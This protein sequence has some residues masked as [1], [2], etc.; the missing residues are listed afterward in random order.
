ME[1]NVP[2]DAMTKIVEIL[3][4]LSS[5]DRARAVSAALTL[6]G[7]VQSKAPQEG[8]DD[9]I[10]SD[11]DLGVLS[12]RTRHWMNQNGISVTELQHVFHVVDGGAEVIS[13]IPGRNKKEQTY[14]AYV[15]TGLG[16]FL[17]TGNAA[18]TDKAARALC[19][20]SG[21][22][23]RANHAVHLRDRG[24]E[25]TGTKEKGWTLTAPGLK[26]AAELVKE[27]QV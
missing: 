17:V 23:D 18:F 1:K 13:A 11:S 16:Q 26:R 24:N 4:P 19:E 27:L 15:L 12:P 21:C 7:D 8:A 20:A 25:F 3:T 10:A 9:Q 6:L 2:L 14:S 22:Y 5:E